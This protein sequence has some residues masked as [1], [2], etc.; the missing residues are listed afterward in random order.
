[1]LRIGEAARQAGV[2]PHALR[3]Y[4]SLG[5]IRCRRSGSGYRLYDRETLERVRFIRRAA[6]LGFTLEEIAQILQLRD[7]GRAPCSQV[8]AWLDEK[9]EHLNAQIRILTGLRAELVALRSQAPAVP[10]DPSGYSS[11]YCALLEGRA[12][13][14]PAA[15]TRPSD[16]GRARS[17]S[18]AHPLR[19]R[20]GRQEGR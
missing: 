17:P 10:A 6:Q 4:E 16:H 5:L 7:E 1:M 9:I 15:A 12:G 14:I 3:Y 8:V 19:R 13:P 2:S 20:H 11:G 18:R